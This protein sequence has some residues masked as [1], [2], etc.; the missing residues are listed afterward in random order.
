ME[1]NNSKN[2]LLLDATSLL[3]VLLPIAQISFIYLPSGLKSIYLQQDAFLGV[4]LV[5]LVMSYISIV[6][7]KSRPWFTFIFPFHKQKM[8]EYNEW[9]KQVYEASSAMN[10]V[11][12]EQV[13]EAKIK[14][15]LKGLEA[16]KVKRPFQVNSEN[17][18]GIFMGVLFINALSFLVLGLSNSSGWLSTLQSINYFFLIIFSVLV[19]VIYRDTTNNSKRFNDDVKLSTSRAIELAVRS[20]CFALQPQVKF[21]STHGGDGISNYFV[22]VEFE[23]D[24]Y[25]ICTNS[26]A[27]KI[28]YCYKLAKP[29]PSEDT[30]AM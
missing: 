17:R 11:S 19:L 26:G 3:A 23:G 7:Y 15:F 22:R 10:F 6:A 18:I 20:N 2:G 13:S 27:T 4:S 8:E 9:Q 30:L 24:E 12:G 5:T 1:Q 25:E 16:K 14:K 21:I 28:V 29:T